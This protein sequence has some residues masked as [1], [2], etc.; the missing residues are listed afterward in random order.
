MK[1]QNDNPEQGDKRVSP[2]DHRKNASLKPAGEAV[3]SYEDAARRPPA[4]KQIHRRRPL[5]PIPEAAEDQDPNKNKSDEN[6]DT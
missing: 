4:G 6:V 1:K 5:P 3:V 2:S